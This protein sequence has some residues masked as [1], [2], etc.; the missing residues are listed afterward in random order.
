MR[1][2]TVTLLA[3]LALGVAGCGEANAPAREDEPPAGE[4][5]SLSPGELDD[6][7][8]AGEAP[9]KEPAARGYTVQR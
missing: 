1:G 3:A 2:R 9:E 5:T 6:E 7:E 4:E 8:T